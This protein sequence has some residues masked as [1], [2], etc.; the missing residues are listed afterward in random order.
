MP[1]RLFRKIR[2]KNILEQIKRERKVYVEEL[3]SI[4]N[5]STSS[6]RLD[7]AEL[8]KLGLISRIYGGAVLPEDS[9]K[10]QVNSKPKIEIS[11]PKLEIRSK[12]NLKEKEAIGKLAASLISDGDTLIIDGGSTTQYLVKHLVNKKGLTVIT[13]SIP[14]IS[15]LMRIK[16][17][18][19]YLLGGLIYNDNLVLS[20]DF[21]IDSLDKIHVMKAFLGM[22]G[23]S[24]DGGLT[25]AN[26]SASTVVSTKKKMI[27]SSDMLYILCDSS[28]IGRTCLMPVAPV[29]E[30]DFLVT[31]NK[32]R[33]DFI[34]QF[35]TLNINVEIAE[36]DSS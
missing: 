16:D 6:I 14:Q 36:T 31:D 34:E 7:L 33:T 28:K 17:S 8:D 13:N 9:I 11:H 32:V 2:L 20:G 3:A 30:M 4:Y 24:I 18:E 21:A 23:I 35:K 29:N 10:E 1:K 15:D 27:K 26:P 25:V 19:I 22:D 5:V 12:K